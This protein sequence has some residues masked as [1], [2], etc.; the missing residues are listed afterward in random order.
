MQWGERGSRFFVSNECP[1]QILE[2]S[3]I[4]R[5][6]GGHARLTDQLQCSFETQLGIISILAGL[7]EC[8]RV[9]IEASHA[10]LLIE[11][12]SIRQKQVKATLGLR[13]RWYQNFKDILDMKGCANDTDHVRVEVSVDRDRDDDSKGPGGRFEGRLTDVERALS[14]V[15]SRLPPVLRSLRITAWS[16]RGGDGRAILIRE[17][18]IGMS[19]EGMLQLV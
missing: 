4:F 11:Q 3:G 2:S 16:Q 15:V 14:L 13:V 17:Q 10:A 7:E 12:P 6:G 8:Q 1:V 18:Q 5:V 9:S 19:G